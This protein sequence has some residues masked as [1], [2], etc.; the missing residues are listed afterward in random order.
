MCVAHASSSQPPAPDAGAWWDNLNKRSV[1]GPAPPAV[2]PAPTTTEGW[3]EQRM[4][5]KGYRD[6]E[7]AK[8]GERQRG[9]LSCVCCVCG[10]GALLWVLLCC[11]VA[12]F[13]ASMQCALKATCTEATCTATPPSPLTPTVWDAMRAVARERYQRGEMP[14]W[15]KPAWLDIEEAPT[16]T[17]WRTKGLRYYQQ[18]ARWLGDQAPDASS[19]GD[20]GEG[21]SGNDN[22]GGGGGRW[23]W[24][25]EE[26]P[27]WPL[28]DW[29]SHPMRW[30]TL[31]FAALL[32]AGG[33]A[34]FAAH[35]SAEAAQ[36]GLGA[37][38]VLGVCGAAMSDMQHGPL[39]HLGVKVA[40]G[41][42]D[43]VGREGGCCL[44]GGGLRGL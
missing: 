22:S 4:G 25:R 11:G 3:N 1:V 37:G 35:G 20:G 44:S 40:W 10:G 6:F 8:R 15:F 43:A 30:W 34:A 12:A 32:A 9:A 21:G 14:A 7:N 39:G 26:D 19:G 23:R 36:I 18:D 5:V 38:A 27:Y 24:W 29:G 16:N 31:G 42:L 41:E 17:F 13:A 33:L 2:D 28:R